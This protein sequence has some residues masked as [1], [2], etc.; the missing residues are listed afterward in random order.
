MSS[1][2]VR[3]TKYSTSSTELAQ[4]TLQSEART[5]ILLQYRPYIRAA[6]N[7]RSTVAR[8]STN[9]KLPTNIM[10]L[11]DHMVHGH[12]DGLDDNRAWTRVTCEVLDSSLFF[13]SFDP[14]MWS[15]IS[16]KAAFLAFNIETATVSLSAKGCDGRKRP[17]VV[18]RA[19][20]NE[21]AGRSATRTR[22]VIDWYS[23]YSTV[24]ISLG[25]LIYSFT[26]LT[27]INWESF[28][29]PPLIKGEATPLPQ[30]DTCS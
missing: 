27:K 26:Y 23:Q 4:P 21:K 16:E 20:F 22:M 9:L 13:T 19:A 12:G 17:A 29:S 11:N 10:T 24:T 7:P 28:C 14:A 30:L 18:G 25:S 6:Y 8:G 1:V 2:G 15:R 3:G 5:S